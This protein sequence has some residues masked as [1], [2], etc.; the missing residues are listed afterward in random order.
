MRAYHNIRFIEHPD[1]G[2][3]Q[4]QG[5]ASHVG[6]IPEK[7]GV[8]KPYIRNSASRRSIRRYL[9]RVDRRLQ[10]RLVDISKHS[11]REDN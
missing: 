4:S 9:K 3:I 1:I 5:R 6:K 11:T 10:D 8:F 7:C 2:D